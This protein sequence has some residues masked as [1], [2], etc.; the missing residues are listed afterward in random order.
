MHGKTSNVMATRN[1]TSSK[2]DDLYRRLKKQIVMSE[3][4]P[5]QQ[6]VELEL[7]GT[8]GCSQST[9]R[10]ALL[11]LQED[12]LI[13]RQGYRGTTVSPVTPVESEIFL[14]LRRMLEVRAARLSLERL[15][16]ADI[17]AL[18]RIVEAMEEAAGQDDGYALFE[19]DLEFHMKLF[20]IACLPAL[21]PVLTRCS[22]VNHR[23][24]I[25]QS[26]K[27]RALLE[28]A[29]RHR[30]IIGA[31]Q[32]GNAEF[33]EEAVS[34]HVSSIFD[35]R[36]GDT[37]DERSPASRMSDAMRNVF[38][39]LAREEA[40]Y[41]NVTT[42][43]PAEGRKIFEQRHARWNR[44]DAQR[45]AIERFEIPQNPFSRHPT[46]PIPAV[47]IQ[48]VNTESKGKLLYI[49]GGGWTFGSTD[50]FMGIM[51]RLAER[52]GFAVFG[53]DYALA[54]EFPFPCGLNDCTWAWRWLR[55][56]DT[57]GQP[58]FV[59][60]D[61]SGANL[62][63][64]MMLDLRSLDE[65]QPQGAALVYGVYCGEEGKES[66]RLFGQGQ[67]GLTTE[68]MAWFLDNYRPAELP[69][70]ARPRLFPVEADLHDLPPLLLIAAELDPLRDDSIK[71]ARK[72]ALTNTP[73]E[74][75]QVAG[76]IHNFL[77]WSDALPE[78]VATLDNIAAF[79]QLRSSM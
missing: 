56:Q 48:T 60:G 19:R 69:E 24:K 22:V 18:E 5:G 79:M 31:L 65:L 59:A 27:R 67:F 34:H 55:G 32:A 71:L 1:E 78:A 58:W 41:P 42:L 10:E 70:F 62:A 63:L 37:P 28:T 29:Q 51:S 2:V 12:G 57:S 33:V 23:N 14:E 17:D 21:T 64:A 3:L 73:F 76:V 20:E 53:V 16:E 74:F 75:S 36:S 40:N 49:H 61:S 15:T 8:L 43:S 68:R 35:T 72:L 45:F 44:I 77:H 25:S 6:L 46:R 7:A 38:V 52:T 50:S 47:R 13:V 30:N 9:V 54:P 26:G 66:H 39:Q 4:L 11:R